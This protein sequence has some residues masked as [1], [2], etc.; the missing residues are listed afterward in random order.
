MKRWLCRFFLVV[1]I[2]SLLWIPHRPASPYLHPAA[3]H[4]SVLSQNGFVSRWCRACG[5]R[6]LDSLGVAL[7]HWN[8]PCP[9]WHS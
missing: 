6:A 3:E 4:Q 9:T 7:A 1:G 5:P 2:V 8:F